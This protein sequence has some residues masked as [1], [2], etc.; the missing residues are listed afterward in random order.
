[1]QHI[2]QP[3]FKVLKNINLKYQHKGGKFDREMGRNEKNIK[4][5]IGN[6]KT[7]RNLKKMDLKLNNV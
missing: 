4:S 7:N 2:S 1:M 6:K 3:I 5:Y